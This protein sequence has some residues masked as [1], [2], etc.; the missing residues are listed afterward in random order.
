MKINKKIKSEEF[1]CDLFEG[2]SVAQEVE[3]SLVEDIE[4]RK[5]HI[6]LDFYDKTLE[7]GSIEEFQQMQID[8]LK[9]SMDCKDRFHYM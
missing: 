7:C 4:R 5:N 6:V 1:Q 8:I 2:D 3:A 9:G